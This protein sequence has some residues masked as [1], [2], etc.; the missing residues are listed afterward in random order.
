MSLI[1]RSTPT[2]RVF[3]SST[4]KDFRIEREIL[5]R[6]VFPRLREL[7]RR[8]GALFQAVDLRWGIS[9][10]AALDQQTLKI[11]LDEL[12]R[13]QQISPIPNFLLLLG[14][15]YGWQPLPLAINAAEFDGIV[16]HLRMENVAND[17][18]NLLL[19]W[20]RRDD[21]ALPP[22]YFLRSRTSRYSAYEVWAAIENDLRG[23]LQ[24]GASLSGVAQPDAE[25]Y[26][27]SATAQE[28]LNGVINPP[29][30]TVK[31]REHAFSFLREFVDMPEQGR[32]LEQFCNVD[33]DGHRE[34][35]LYKRLGDLKN[36]LADILGDSQRHY[37]LAWRQRRCRSRFVSRLASD[38]YFALARVIEQDLQRLQ[39][40]PFDQAEQ[41]RHL[42][43]R[44]TRLNGFHGRGEEIERILGLLAQREGKPALIVGHGGSGKS[45]LMASV[46]KKL[47]HRSETCVVVRFI[48]VTGASGQYESLIRSIASE[49]RSFIPS[50]PLAPRSFDARAWQTWLYRVADELTENR[51]LVLL[52]DAVDQLSSADQVRFVEWLPPTLPER[53]H[54]VFSSTPDTGGQQVCAL[55]G[56]RFGKTSILQLD[57]L[58]REDGLKILEAWLANASRKLDV[59]QKAVVLDGFARNGLPLYLKL[60][61]QEAVRWRSGEKVSLPASLDGMV[62]QMLRRLE[63]HEQHGEVLTRHALSLIAAS[64][65]GLAEEELLDLLSATPDVMADFRARSPDSEQIET[66]PF[67]VWARLHGDIGA[68]LAERSADRKLLYVF[69]HRIIAE[70]VQWRYFPD[71]SGSR[72]FHAVLA[73]YF[74]ASG[75][76][77]G[78]GRFRQPDLRKLS[79]APFHLMKIEDYGR[80]LELLGDESYRDA[81][82]A[83][84]RRYEWLDEFAACYELGG[85]PAQGEA[86]LVCL[87]AHLEGLGGVV[88]GALSLEDIHAFFV[89]RKNNTFH[90]AL[91]VQGTGLRAG[92]ENKLRREIRMGF[93]ARQANKLRRA[94][95]LDAAIELLEQLV[96]E[97]DGGREI[98]AERSRAEYDTGYVHYLK[99]DFEQAVRWLSLSAKSAKYSGNTQGYWISRIVC[100]HV[101]LMAALG[102]DLTPALERFARLI[103]QGEVV[104]KKLAE[105]DTTA[106][107]WMT[108]V[109]AHRFE[110]A[111][112]KGDA[113]LAADYYRQLETDPWILRFGDEASLNKARAR[114]ALLEGDGAEALE[115]LSKVLPR[116]TEL[117]RDE[118]LRLG[119]ALAWDYYD[120]ARAYELVGNTTM[121]RRVKRVALEDLPADAGNRPWQKMILQN[122]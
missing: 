44:E 107:R 27:L 10:N 60:A 114:L 121:A 83:A 46:S 100:G 33:A 6:R 110:I 92:D 58:P 76:W 80:L 102:G 17:R 48:G 81:K 40:M 95:K 93:V 88:N 63:L 117:A 66:L 13:C 106:E 115:R 24:E 4:F 61:F 19:R 7:C 55:F 12:A 32:D 82:L 113:A 29:E 57:S 41:I 53:I 90:E 52:V 37:P 30:G 2:I 91:L 56:R 1:R 112:L 16:E 3:V 21:N 120:L 15:R 118:K 25:K 65:N 99:G 77:S 109:R 86:V 14:D 59:A 87:L 71:A 108:N 98:A 5:Q 69:Y 35:D 104:F 67:S 111:Y 103:D 97:F 26:F 31:V 11:C 122:S 36:S 38:V 64:C 72:H 47:S 23:L 22:V 42:D 39:L 84:G 45:S 68:Y 78:R 28:I 74:Y 34:A 105:T 8:Y 79:E 96:G 18:L 89:Y 43:F 54:L 50:A 62:N 85:S 101:K 119:E 75:N 9:E 51:N 20:Y 70:Q 49:I 73:D 94:G 116:F